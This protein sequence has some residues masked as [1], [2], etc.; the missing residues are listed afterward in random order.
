MQVSLPLT[1]L[2]GILVLFL[3]RKAELKVLH[4][5]AVIMLGFFLAST[6]LAARIGQL[7]TMIAGLLGGSIHPH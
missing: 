4:A 1:L 6:V 5:V 2:L 7:D 3:I